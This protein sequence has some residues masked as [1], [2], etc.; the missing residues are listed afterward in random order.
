MPMALPSSALDW[1]EDI[2]LPV[3][4]FGEMEIR[5]A[6]KI[7][8]VK[9]IRTCWCVRLSLCLCGCLSPCIYTGHRVHD[10]HACTASTLKWCYVIFLRL[11]DRYLAVE[12]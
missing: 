2:Q 10:L 5:I 9:S 4:E 8:Y 3:L 1:D 11:E 6:K 12:C 7:A